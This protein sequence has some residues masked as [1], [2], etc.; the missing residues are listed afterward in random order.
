MTSEL[1]Q[2][3]TMLV[4][5]IVYGIRSHLGDDVAL[6]VRQDVDGRDYVSVSP[7]TGQDSF[8]CAH[9]AAGEVH[10][11][12]ESTVDEKSED[13]DEE[14]DRGEWAVALVCDLA[15]FGAAR[16]RT[17]R[18]L[19]VSLN[20]LHIFRSDAERRAVLSTSEGRIVGEFRPFV[21]AT[22]S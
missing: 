4:R 22:L 15:R 6:D 5:A 11:T 20:Q 13:L 18:F 16:V 8:L 3:D 21:E 17:S 14:I 12:D 1:D 9:V 7:V 2:Q 10:I 19:P